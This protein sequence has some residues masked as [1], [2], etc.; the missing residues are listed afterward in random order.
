MV[1]F[2]EHE[3]SQ[4]TQRRVFFKQTRQIIG[5]I[6]EIIEI[7]NGCHLSVACRTKN[8]IE[9]TSGVQ[10]RTVKGVHT[11]N[12]TQSARLWVPVTQASFTPGTVH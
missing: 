7:S 6:L 1:P 12:G 10:T 5:K 3:M 4:R 8:I 11:Q 9:L 2:F